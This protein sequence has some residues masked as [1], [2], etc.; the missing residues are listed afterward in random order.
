MDQLI[1]PRRTR[2][3]PSRSR[4]PEATTEPAGAESVQGAAVGEKGVDDTGSSEPPLRAPPVTELV[5][6][7]AFEELTRMLQGFVAAIT[8]RGTAPPATTTEQMRQDPARGRVTHLL[9]EFLKLD[10][11]TF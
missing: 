10:A 4:A 8:Q 9:R 2:G 3:R 5:S 6:A 11:T 1:V 7:A